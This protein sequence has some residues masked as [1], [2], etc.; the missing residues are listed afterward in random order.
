MLKL[1][2]YQDV[3]YTSKKTGKQVDGYNLAVAFEKNGYEGM[4]VDSVYISKELARKTGYVPVVGQNIDI[5]YEKF[6]NNF[7]PAEINAVD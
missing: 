4:A 1:V 7:Y 6:G 3:N 2:G 5:R